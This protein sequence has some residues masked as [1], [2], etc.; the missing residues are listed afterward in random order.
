M[1][2]LSDAYIPIAIVVLAL[3]VIVLIV[4]VSR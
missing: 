2:N 3:L 4:Q 1:A